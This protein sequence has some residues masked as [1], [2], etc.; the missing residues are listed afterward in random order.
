MSTTKYI[1][2]LICPTKWNCPTIQETYFQ[3]YNI[4]VNLFKYASNLG[5]ESLAIS[6]L[7][8]TDEFE[9]GMVALY[10]ALNQLLLT[11][12]GK[13]TKI[14]IAALDREAL[15]VFKDYLE[16]GYD[17]TILEL[18]YVDANENKSKIFA[19][20]QRNSEKMK[21]IKYEE[22]SSLLN[23][24]V[25]VM[26]EKNCFMCN[27]REFL[28]TKSNIINFTYL[29]ECRDSKI[30]LYG[31]NSSKKC[32][33]CQ[34]IHELAQIYFCYFDQNDKE[35][36]ICLK[37][38][39]QNFVNSL[40]NLYCS[41]CLRDVQG[42]L[43]LN[44][45]CSLHHVCDKCTNIT[46]K[47]A[48]VNCFFC[49]LYE[50]YEKF[51]LNL[52][53]APNNLSI[54]H[55]KI[56]CARDFCHLDFSENGSQI[57]K[58]NAC[59][60]AACKKKDLNSLCS[61]CS[62]FK[63]F[64]LMKKYYGI[65]INEIDYAKIEEDVIKARELTNKKSFQSHYGNVQNKLKVNQ[66]N[67]V[68]NKNLTLLNDNIDDKNDYLTDDDVDEDD[69]ERNDDNDNETDDESNNEI[70]D[71]KN[72]ETDDESNNEIDDNNYE[73]SNNR[74]ENQN[75]NFSKVKILEDN[76]AS[77]N[78]L[79]GGVKEIRHLNENLPG[80]EDTNTIQVGFFLP[81]GIQ[82]VR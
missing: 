18:V 28:I 21:N 42:K 19:S 45:F 25:D 26:V 39:I 78:L 50:F 36:I 62:T 54:N 3:I 43:N 30:S 22:K 24:N 68:Q 53:L 13:L 80:Y 29:K 33:P 35:G 72:N 60:H 47:F 10:E 52:N 8:I 51:S 27:G 32:A 49:I 58:L 11:E 79:D 38:C 9:F 63:I 48:P 65:N 75:E 40:K 34:I 77:K 20:E 15:I 14:Y 16:N 23:Q 55:H 46:L 82:K 69:D 71:E 81:N 41:S 5:I 44:K 67:T 37:C 12:K 64:E 61:F 2:H 31:I 59:G 76:I 57:T 74:N 73:T 6:F 4:Y 56:N 17:K 66:T 70:D 7:G 1:L